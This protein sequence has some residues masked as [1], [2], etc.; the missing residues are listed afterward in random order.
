MN[1]C[2]KVD[3]TC[4]CVPRGLARDKGEYI[5]STHAIGCA[6]TADSIPGPVVAAAPR[7]RL[8]LGRPLPLLLALPLPR[9]RARRVVSGGDLGD[10]GWLFVPVALPAEP[11]LTLVESAGTVASAVAAA[12]VPA[13]RAGTRKPRSASEARRYVSTRGFGMARARRTG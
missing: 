3:S 9:G 4:P 10:G 2:G 5:S 11:G 7:A 13:A 12:A 6:G 1:R 8:A